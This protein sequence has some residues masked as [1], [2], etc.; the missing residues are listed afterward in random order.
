RCLRSARPYRPFLIWILVSGQLRACNWPAGPRYQVGAIYLRL[1][2]LSPFLTIRHVASRFC[3]I[4]QPDIA[5]SIRSSIGFASSTATWCRTAELI[6]P[7]RA[8]AV[9]IAAFTLSAG[10][11]SP[12][13]YSPTQSA[14]AERARSFAAIAV[15]TPDIAFNVLPTAFGAASRIPLAKSFIVI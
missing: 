13:E 7:P 4:V 5:D 3:C 14:P 12:L 6:S 9:I 2:L 10:L 8:V 1:L 15:E 11:S